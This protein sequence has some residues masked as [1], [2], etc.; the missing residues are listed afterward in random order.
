MLVWVISQVCWCSAGREISK[1]EGNNRL[2]PSSTML[3]E[4]I[5]EGS[6][7][8]LSVDSDVDTVLETLFTVVAA[9]SPK[10]TVLRLKASELFPNRKQY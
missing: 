9:L 2:A 4:G 5:P 8:P 3:P 6:F 7:Q 1:E 10:V